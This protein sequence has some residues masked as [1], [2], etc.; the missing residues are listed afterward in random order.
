MSSE[1]LSGVQIRSI[2][3]HPYQPDR[4][5]LADDQGRC[6]SW[7]LRKNNEYD[8]LMKQPTQLPIHDVAFHP[9]LV[10]HLVSAGQDGNLWL[11]SLHPSAD[12]QQ[13]G[14]MNDHPF[15]LLSLVVTEQ[16]IL[17]STQGSALAFFASSE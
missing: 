16:G 1:A 14:L 10:E 8:M 2:K 12:S 11:S 4:W 17:A 5:A 15:P 6:F 13:L 3:R 7:T 9:T